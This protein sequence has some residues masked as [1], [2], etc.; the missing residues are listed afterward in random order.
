MTDSLNY[1]KK[2]IIY[3]SILVVILFILLLFV[4]PSLS[5]IAAENQLKE[6]LATENAY[7]ES[8]LSTSSL[9]LQNAAITIPET[10]QLVGLTHGNGKF[11][12]GS[13]AN[14]GTLTVLTPIV[15]KFI[16]GVL[17]TNSPRIDILAPMAIN[18]GG[19]GNFIYIVLF[20]D[21]GQAAIEKS[22]AFLGDRVIIT[23]INLIEAQGNEEYRAAV[24]YL[25]HASGTALASPPTLE[26]VIEL[27]VLDG[28]FV[29]K[30]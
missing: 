7:M 24:T 21:T 30:N 3:F 9:R 18:Y 20:N 19:S 27:E 10:N 28:K 25:D 4:K 12:T 22:Y 16:P 11:E 26:K 8:L 23:S 17:H 29:T 13:S 14:V 5:Q 1:S 15:T 6:A 2:Q